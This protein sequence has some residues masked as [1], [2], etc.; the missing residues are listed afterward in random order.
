MA[1]NERPRVLRHARRARA[2]L[3]PAVARIDTNG[4]IRF[5]GAA[6]LLVALL[7]GACGNEGSTV[8]N[9]L[10][11]FVAAG[12]TAAEER[13]LPRIAALIGD[14]YQD[15]AGRTRKDLVRLVGGYLI[16]HQQI[17]L[18]SIVDGIDVD[19]PDTAQ[20][21]VYVGMSGSAELDDSEERILKADMHRLDLR[22]V[23]RDG[24][25]LL[26]SARWRR[27]TPGDLL[28]WQATS[29]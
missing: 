14:L 25:W 12:E 22:V 17:H 19:A 1:E 8:E 23:R 29:G 7:V 13:S 20:L 15:D 4:A 28:D 9:E 3:V 10:R 6:T 24:E 18:I 11:A 5:R 16:G 21:T 2:A 27:V 26:Q